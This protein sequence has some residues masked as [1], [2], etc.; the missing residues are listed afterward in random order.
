MTI[1]GQ[2][3]NGQI[4]LQTT[5]KVNGELMRAYVNTRADAIRLAYYWNRCFI[6]DKLKAWLHQRIWALRMI[7]DQDRIAKAGNLIYMLDKYKSTSLENLSLLIYLQRD[8]FAYLA[9]ESKSGHYKIYT[10]TVLS[11]MDFCEKMQSQH[12]LKILKSEQ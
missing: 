5:E 3:V 9:P 10:N 6:C 1:I 8:L 2:H 12:V 7:N 11:I 4:M